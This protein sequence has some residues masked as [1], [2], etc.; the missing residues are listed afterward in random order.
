MTSAPASAGVNA[1]APSANATRTLPTSAINK[2]TT[3]SPSPSPS[4]QT[5]TKTSLYH[6]GLFYRELSNELFNFTQLDPDDQETLQAEIE[7]YLQAAEI[8]RSQIEK[9]VDNICYVLD[10]ISGKVSLIEAEQQRLHALKEAELKRYDQ[11][12]DYM[13]G[14]LSRIFPGEKKIPLDMHLI[15]SRTSSSVEIEDKLLP[16]EVRLAD[17]P[18]ELVAETI[19]QFTAAGIPH[20]L[21]SVNTRTTT[22]IKPDKTLIKQAIKNGQSVPGAT[23]K[24]NTNWT[25][26]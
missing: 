26:K 10:F 6:Q 20:E 3:H 14:N 11:I 17:A 23:L 13:T 16:A 1:S 22:T 15:S 25:I 7:N 4:V 8:T 5:T 19:E 12:R 21:L 18:L 9:K 2:S 24:T